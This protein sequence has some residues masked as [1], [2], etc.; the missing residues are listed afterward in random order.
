MLLSKTKGKKTVAG[1]GDKLFAEYNV[2]PY[3]K[4]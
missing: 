4:W 2:S 1:N 3:N